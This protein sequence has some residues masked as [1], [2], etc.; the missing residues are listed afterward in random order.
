MSQTLAALPA[1][2]SPVKV[3]DAKTLSANMAAID[4]LNPRQV[5]SLSVISKIHEL[6]SQGGTDYR[7]NHKQLRID[8]QNLLGVFSVAG[9]DVG[10]FSKMRAVIDWNAAKVQDATFSASVNTLVSEMAGLR[11]TPEATLAMFYQFLLYKLS[12]LGA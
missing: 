2:S 12:L 9:Y 10:L 7:T 11:E 3:T 6:V 1:L 4:N 5:L 8:A